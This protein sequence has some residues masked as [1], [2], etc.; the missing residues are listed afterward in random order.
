MQ[1]T[2]ERILKYLIEN[3]VELTIKTD[4][5]STVLFQTSHGNR[6]SRRRIHKEDY[7]SDETNF[8][9]IIA[10]NLSKLFLSFKDFDTPIK[11]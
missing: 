6:H 1:N 2:Y 9:R 7:F 4:E 3:D 11:L 8:E 10:N 5:L